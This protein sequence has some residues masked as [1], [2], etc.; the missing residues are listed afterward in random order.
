VVA[1]ADDLVGAG[2]VASLAR[3]GGNMTGLSLIDVDISAKQLGC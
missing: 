3:P 1:A 2:I